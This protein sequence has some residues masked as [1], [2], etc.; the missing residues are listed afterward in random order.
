MF[1]F[2]TESLIPAPRKKSLR[3]SVDIVGNEA[4]VH[5]GTSSFK[6]RSEF[7]QLLEHEVMDFALFGALA[8]AVR[9]N[10]DVETDIPV[11]Q[12]AVQAIRN[13]VDILD[14]WRVR[15]S[16]PVAFRC[17]NIVPDPSPRT[18][19]DE[20]ICLSGG[21]DSTYAAMIG[22][23]SGTLKHGLLIAGAD[24]PSA[25]AP[26]FVELRA[27][28]QALSDKLGI[29]LIVAETSIRSLP[30]YFN[31]S[32]GFILAMMLAFH[33]PGMKKGNIASDFTLAQ[34]YGYA[35]WGNSR[36]LVETLGDT[37]F[38]IAHLGTEVGRTAKLAAIANTD[39]EL[40]SELSFCID[41][42]QGGNCG[43]C[44]KCV[45][46]KLN[47]LAAGV[48]PEPYFVE[49]FDLAAQLAKLKMPSTTF[50]MRRH[51]VFLKDIQSSLPEGEVS[52]VLNHRMKILRRKITPLGK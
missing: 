11:T 6:I 21:I 29:D 17:T 10:A 8:F 27:R 51:M 52:S 49:N 37:W 3:L 7:G 35:P 40:L 43:V 32:H 46:T 16:Y 48:A 31:I 30:V 25:E 12:R 20:L 47:M 19:A 39:P 5:L 42:R 22:T 28:V 34:E 9:N 33:A 38:P 2:L 23:Q 50:A 26:G 4:T 41:K 1:H 18:D 44:E 45:R 14:M 24:Y 15:R 36:P 13:A